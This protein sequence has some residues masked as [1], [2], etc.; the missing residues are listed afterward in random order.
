MLPSLLRLKLSA[1]SQHFTTWESKIAEVAQPLV[2]PER[3]RHNAAFRTAHHQSLF[4][5]L[6]WD[7]ETKY[8]II[9]DRKGGPET[10]RALLWVT[11]WVTEINQNDVRVSSEVNKSWCDEKPSAVDSPEQISL[12]V[13]LECSKTTHLRRQRMLKNQNSVLYEYEEEG[14]IKIPLSMVFL[15]VNCKLMQRI[16]L[17]YFAKNPCLCL[18]QK[19]RKPG[20][21][22][23]VSSSLCLHVEA[24]LSLIQEN[25]LWVECSFWISTSSICKTWTCSAWMEACWRR[26][27]LSFLRSNS[28]LERLSWGVCVCV[29]KSGHSVCACASKLGKF[30]VFFLTHVG[31][32]NQASESL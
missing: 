11:E 15:R 14:H 27:A 12:L 8:R 29:W 16:P 30:K 9:F 28:D 6:L 20:L 7:S 23:K 25:V 1:E 26:V 13:S 19:T 18:I 17:Q 2:E 21:A 22:S 32:S 4:M 5:V 31:G 10:S 3:S 24:M